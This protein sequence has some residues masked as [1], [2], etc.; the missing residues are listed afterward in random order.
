MAIANTRN[1]DLDYSCLP[2]E[3]YG[4]TG[5]AHGKIGKKI[6]SSEIGKT[7]NTAA[8]ALLSSVHH[9]ACFVK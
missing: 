9:L 4:P 2:I 3:T 7:K 1:I 5:T 8:D 6:L